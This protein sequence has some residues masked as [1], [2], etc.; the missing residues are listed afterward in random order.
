MSGT[1]R[2]SPADLYRRDELRE[3]LTL[4]IPLSASYA[5]SS[6]LGFVDAAMVGRL[7]AAALGAVGIGNG[8][9]IALGVVGLGIVAGTDPL[10]AQAIGAGE[11]REARRIFWQGLRLSL[12][13]SGPLIALMLAVA[14]A[15]ESFGV[16][17]TT[18]S[19]TRAFLIGRSLNILTLLAA[20][21]ARGYLQSV[22]RTQPILISV[23]IANI[24]N[25]LFDALLIYGDGA[26]AAVQLRG[27][28][29]PALG[30]LGAGLASSIASALSAVFLLFAVRGVPVERADSVS[31]LD[32]ALIR[33]TLRLGVP[34]GLHLLAEVGAFTI[35]AVLA[36]RMGKATVAGHHVALSLAGLTFTTAMG[37][38]AATSVRVGKAV[39]RQ[40]TVGARRAGFQGMALA[41]AV[42]SG[43][44]LLFFLAPGACGGILTDQ[45]D[46]LRAA[47]PL[48]QIAALFQISDAIQGVSASALRGAGDTRFTQIANWFG[49]YGIGLPLAVVLGFLTP[50]GARGIWWGLSA[51]LTLVAALLFIR[52]ERL[53]RR[54]LV[55]VA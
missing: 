30:V 49:H 13:T 8:L 47:V 38:G 51:G 37:I 54:G 36:A 42:M 29:L 5:G 6:L 43:C 7:G 10:I 35:A 41:C 28:G 9:F 14:L 20:G 21:A 24:A 19:Y 31:T 12:W 40:D 3:L 50:L 52:F 27:I 18:A 17:A 26:L 46:V 22:G 23:L 39:G 33:K 53:S 15:L 25:I 34:I 1:G 55:R 32:M 48:I 11:P 45:S 2:F 44:G 4:A 16:D